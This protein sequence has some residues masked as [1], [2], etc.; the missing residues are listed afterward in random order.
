ML[1]GR[2]FQGVKV[3]NKNYLQKLLC[4]TTHNRYIL[5]TNKDERGQCCLFCCV[6]LNAILSRSIPKL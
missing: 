6:V 5:V 4:V 1:I 2:G 3:I